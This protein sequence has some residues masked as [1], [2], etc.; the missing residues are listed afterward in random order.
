MN[1]FVSMLLDGEVASDFATKVLP[2]LRYILFAIIIACAIVLTQCFERNK[3][4][5][6][7]CSKQGCFTR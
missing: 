4:R 1:K 6:L 2:V 7:L 5:K 3:T